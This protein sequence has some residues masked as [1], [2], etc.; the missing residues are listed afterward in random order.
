[1]NISKKKN[2]NAKKGKTK[3]LWILQKTF[4]GKY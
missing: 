3:C 1:M 2:I 4:D